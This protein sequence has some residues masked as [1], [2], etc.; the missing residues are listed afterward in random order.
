MNHAIRSA[1]D[2]YAALPTLLPTLGTAMEGGVYVGAVL[3][4]NQLFGI[5]VSPKAAGE[6]VGAWGN[7]GTAIEGTTRGVDGL[8]NTNAMA[9]HGSEIAKQV[10]ALTINDYRDWYIPARDELELLYRHLKPTTGENYCSWK[11]GE[12]VFS[13]P[14]G[15]QYTAQHPIQTTLA[16]FQEGGAQALNREWHWSSTQ[17]SA[18]GAFI[19]DF[20]DGY[21]DDNDKSLKFR[22]R[23]VRR[24]LI[25]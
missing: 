3:L 11:D 1:L 10:R 7:Y 8:A 19:Q 23:A 15:Q 24:F 25:A 16:D 17:Y 12:N 20:D 4:N 5:I 21:Q 18:Y 13:V 22:V 9:A 14:T 6:I 2:H